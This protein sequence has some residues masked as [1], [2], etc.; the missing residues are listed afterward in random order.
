VVI[1]EEGGE[2]SAGSGEAGM[3]ADLK[4]KIDVPVVPRQVI[5]CHSLCKYFRA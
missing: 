5:V 3:S 4:E 1:D 2:G